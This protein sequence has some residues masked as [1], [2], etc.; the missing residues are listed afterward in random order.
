MKF[1]WNFCTGIRNK[2]LESD[3][4]LDHCLGW[5]TATYFCLQCSFFTLILVLWVLI[6]IIIFLT[7]PNVL[8]F[9]NARCPVILE[10]RQKRHQSWKDK[11]K[12][13]AF[14]CKYLF[15]G[16]GSGALAQQS[17]LSGA[18]CMSDRSWS[19]CIRSEIHGPTLSLIILL[20]I[21]WLK[22]ELECGSTPIWG[23]TENHI[24]TNH[25]KALSAVLMPKFIYILLSS[26]ARLQPPSNPTPHRPCVLVSHIML[27]QTW[28]A[29]VVSIT[30]KG[31]D[32]TREESNFFHS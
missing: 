10:S 20:S 25:N 14:E 28:V 11:K 15:H 21:P 6:Y 26:N 7:F 24:I 32:Q 30:L 1:S 18:P 22:K 29:E 13:S 4:D 5:W 19:N 23:H 27:R 2:W 16:F 9:F 17:G 12:K 8:Y 31:L 3:S